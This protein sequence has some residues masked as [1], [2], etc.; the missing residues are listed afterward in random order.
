MP[1][2]F[3]GDINPTPNTANLYGD[4]MAVATNIT[5]NE[6]TV[7]IETTDISLGYTFESV[8]GS[9]TAKGSDTSPDVALLFESQKHDGDSLL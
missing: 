6:I 5:L 1:L 4:D 8:S 9:L 3:C 7:T 2:N